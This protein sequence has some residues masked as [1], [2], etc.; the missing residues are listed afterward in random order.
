MLGMVEEPHVNPE[1]EKVPKRHV[2]DMPRVNPAKW[3]VR[4]MFSVDPEAT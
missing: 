3:H 1:T 4:D 2:Q